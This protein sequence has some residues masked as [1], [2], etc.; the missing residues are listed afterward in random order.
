MVSGMDLVAFGGVV[1][2]V[3][4][5][6]LLA[7]LL[8]WLTLWSARRPVNWPNAH[9]GVATVTSS[10]FT[11]PNPEGPATVTVKVD[12]ENQGGEVFASE[13][14]RKVP[15]PA[16][17][18]IEPG[19]QFPAMYR[20]DR[21]EK[22]KIARGSHQD[23]AQEFFEQVRLRDGL[24]DTA[25]L[26]AD[27]RGRIAYA[28]LLSVRD[29]GERR[30]GLPVRALDLRIRSVEGPEYNH[31]SVMVLTPNQI[32]MLTPGR[33]LRVKYVPENPTHVAVALEPVKENS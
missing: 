19:L 15:V 12:V 26:D 17:S 31:T 25:A 24:L 23:R 30:R 10:H 14:V 20:P 27:R 13:L 7:A 6:A 22:V 8:I 2:G 21:R 28:R 5:F 33:I 4:P 29:T 9:V 16:L 18:L 3:V 1:L 32:R 11:L